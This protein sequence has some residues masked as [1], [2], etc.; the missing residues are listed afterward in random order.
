MQPVMRRESRCMT[1]YLKY[2]HL[3]DY[4]F[5]EVSSRFQ[6]T[7]SI[8]PTDFYMI[9]I[10]KANRSKS[11]IKNRIQ[12]KAGSFSV[13]V[14]RIGTALTNAPDAK[15]RLRLMMTDWGFRLPMGTAI[16]TVLYPDEFT[17]YDV[18]VC[19]V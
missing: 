17:V 5:R 16:L 19:G 3:E 14:E 8:A 2:Y 1:D 18:R 12:S 7:G 15:T 11:K 10:W 4:L 13:G 6:D 9:V